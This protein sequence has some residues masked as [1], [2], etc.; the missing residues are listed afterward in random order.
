MRRAILALT[1]AF[2]GVASPLSAQGMLRLATTTSTQDS[3]L[4]GA[5]LP[6]FERVC[7]CR[8][9]VIAVGSGQALEIGR[10]GDADVLLVH[11]RKAE[12]LFVAEGHARARF[13]VMYNDFVLVGPAGDPAK[14]GGTRLAREAFAAIARAAAPF[15][16]RGD[17]SGTH[18]VEQE[19]WAAAQVAPVPPWYRSLGQGMGETLM[20]A[21][22]QQAYTLTDRATW[23]ALRGRL[24]ALR[25]WL[26]GD[27]PAENSDPRLRNQYGVLAV[28]P[29]R[30]PGVNA[31]LAGRFV[32]WLLSPPTQR[33]IGEFGISR[34]G[35]PLFRPNAAVK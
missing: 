16:S 14:A 34:F 35:Q 17:K 28:S 15:A 31:V 5:I 27:N 8:V 6:D 2:A 30:H 9:S 20:F 33:I 23:M 13:D 26:G 24:P 1:L 10:R 11:S 21:Q 7:A 12:D 18:V 4:L 32:D 3:G 22:E 25:V 29:D 19:T